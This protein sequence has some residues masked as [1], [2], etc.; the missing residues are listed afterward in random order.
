MKL[1]LHHQL[2]LSIKMLIKYDVDLL[3]AGLIGCKRE[4]TDVYGALKVFIISS[5][6][7]YFMDY[8]S[9]SVHSHIIHIHN[10]ILN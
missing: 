5:I 7:L 8:N 4:I 1:L 6:N 9:H 3:L 10:C 2:T